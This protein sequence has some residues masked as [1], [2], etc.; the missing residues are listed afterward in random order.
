MLKLLDQ[1][2][3]LTWRRARHLGSLALLTKDTV[4]RMVTPPLDGTE[5]V[6][7]IETT[8]LRSAGLAA[9]IALFTG[10]VIA[11]Q[12]AH[13]LALFGAKLFLGEVVSFSLVR[14]LGPV[15]TALMV[16]GRVG[17]GITAEIRFGHLW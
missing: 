10:M 7:Q 6:R 17:A 8:G 13:T 14:E 5:L 16:G 1:I 11:L 4:V 2:Y 9:I 15:L 12:T 3:D